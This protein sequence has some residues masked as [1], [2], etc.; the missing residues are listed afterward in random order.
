MKRIFNKIKLI[1]SYLSS[2]FFLNQFIALQIYVDNIIFGSTNER[3]C[4]YL[5]KL[6]QGEFEISMMEELNLFYGLQIRQIKKGIFIYQEKF[7]HELI[8]TFGLENAKEIIG[9]RWQGIQSKGNFLFNLQKQRTR[10]SLWWTNHPF[11]DAKRGR[12]MTKR[13]WTKGLFPCMCWK[14]IFS[15]WH[16]LL[17]MHTALIYVRCSNTCYLTY[18]NL[19]NVHIL[20]IPNFMFWV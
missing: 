16:L 5:S 8:K 12:E 20:S 15:L 4:K 9:I 1:Q 17:V 2:F 11:D 6:M 7:T 14:G 18:S 3:L 10:M 19:L 13:W